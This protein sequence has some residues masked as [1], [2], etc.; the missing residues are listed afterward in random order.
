MNRH[1]AQMGGGGN[2]EHQ[3]SIWVRLII[4][5]SQ[6]MNWQIVL[7]DQ[8]KKEIDKVGLVFVDQIKDELKNATFPSSRRMRL[9][10]DTLLA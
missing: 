5:M 8:M 2:H 3:L 6:R 7:D 4:W 1:H 9:R 10:T